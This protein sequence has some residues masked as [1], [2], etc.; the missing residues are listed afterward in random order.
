MKVQTL[1]DRL[2]EYDPDS[3]VVIYLPQTYCPFEYDLRG[4]VPRSECMDEDNSDYPVEPDRSDYETDPEYNKEYLEAK[5]EYD[6]VIK[7]E[8]PL[9]P[10]AS[11]YDTWQ[12][13]GYYTDAILVMGSQLRYA[14]GEGVVDAAR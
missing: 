7:G 14:N 8:L 9:R 13:G 10:T 5:E 3:E 6:K 12:N 11:K 4:V 2:S 1:I